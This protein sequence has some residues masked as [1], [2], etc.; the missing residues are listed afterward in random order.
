[1]KE[2][3]LDKLFEIA[4]DEALSL[5]EG[6]HSF[7]ILLREDFKLRIFFEDRR[8][9]GDMKKKKFRR[10]FPKALP[11]LSDLICFLIDEELERNFIKLSERFTKLASKKFKITFVDVESAY[12]LKKEE[13]EG[14][15]EFI[16]GEPHVRVRRDPSLIGGFKLLTSDGR[17]FD[18]SL[19]SG[20][21]RLK[22]K[23]AY[24]R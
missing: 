23:L 2:I 17:Y 13:L 16:G 7:L 11:L 8:I 6:L 21:S 3:D 18:C 22:D 4:K 14:I 9:P 12:A 19:I 10:L 5:E 24:A 15:R 1:M 20:I